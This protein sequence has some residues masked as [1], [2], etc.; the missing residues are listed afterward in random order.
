MSLLSL[1][2]ERHFEIYHSSFGALGIKTMEEMFQIP[3][4]YGL[5]K[6]ETNFV[7]II[8]LKQLYID[9]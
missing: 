9:G 8:S 7:K 5:T 6:L 2:S 1:D 3:Y 4:Y